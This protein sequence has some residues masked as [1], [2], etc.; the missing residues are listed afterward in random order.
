MKCITICSVVSLL[1]S[2]NAWSQSFDRL[3]AEKLE[4]LYES[5]KEDL[6]EKLNSP[7]TYNKYINRFFRKDSKIG[8]FVDKANV[9][10][11]TLT[12]DDSSK[13]SLGISWDFSKSNEI[14]QLSL[15]SGA[16]GS[17]DWAFKTRGNV[18]FDSSINPQDFMSL[19]VQYNFTRRSVF[20]NKAQ[21]LENEE[22][23]QRRAE[24]LTWLL[25]NGT[26]QELEEFNSAVRK[27]L[28]NDLYTEVGLNLGFESDQKFENYQFTFGAHTA[29]DFKAYDPQ[30]IGAKINIFDYPSAVLRY[31]TG[32]DGKISV[33]GASIP[34][35][36][37]TADYVHPLEEEISVR[38][39][40]DDSYFRVGA[41][42]A[43]R[44]LAAKVFGEYVYLEMNAR[45]YKE[46]GASNTIKSLG[47]DEQFMYSVGLVTQKGWSISYSEG[48]LPFSQEKDRFF[49]V[50]FKANF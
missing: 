19:N 16:E 14:S 49:G 15:E 43:S 48:D 26:P 30:S 35:L 28:G 4:N 29:L 47:R 12:L 41:E 17:I 23:A 42:I 50:G 11:L 32:I 5:K 18:A 20:L 1:F 6:K 24:R 31:A 21:E 22:I 9:E 45:Y 8:K 27:T 25:R 36:L 38:G 46:L 3:V 40:D 2:N 13:S 34:T 39:G 37:F 7:E 44:S 33:N 10:F